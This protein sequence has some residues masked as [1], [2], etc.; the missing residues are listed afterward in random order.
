[1]STMPDEAPLV[2]AGTSRVRWPSPARD[3]QVAVDSRSQHRH[4][5]VSPTALEG[6]EIDRAPSRPNVDC[7]VVELSAAIQ[8]R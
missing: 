2:G 4:Y 1:M 3:S 8:E 6:P 5:L 7:E